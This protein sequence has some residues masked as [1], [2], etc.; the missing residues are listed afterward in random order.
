MSVC[1]RQEVEEAAG[2]RHGS[3]LQRIHSYQNGATGWGPSPESVTLWRSFRLWL[4]CLSLDT[5]ERRQEVLL[6]EG[7]GSW[8]VGAKAYHKVTLSVPALLGGG[9][10]Q[11]KGNNWEEFPQQSCGSRTLFPQVSQLGSPLCTTNLTRDLLRRKKPG[12]WLPLG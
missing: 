11:C 10:S 3:Y 5:G 6:L 2:P 12:G 1:S 7:K 4:Q 8:Q 9:G